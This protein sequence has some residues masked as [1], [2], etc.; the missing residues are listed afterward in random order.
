[1]F[2]KCLCPCFF[3]FVNSGKI[4]YF[5]KWRYLWLHYRMLLY[6]LIYISVISELILI[7]H[8]QKMTGFLASFQKK[9]CSGSWRRHIGFKM[10]N[11]HN[12]SVFLSFWTIHTPKL[13]SWKKLSEKS[14]QNLRH[15][16]ATTLHDVIISNVSDLHI[17]VEWLRGLMTSQN[18]KKGNTYFSKL[19]SG[20]QLSFPSRVFK[21]CNDDVIYNTR[22]YH[23]CV[24]LNRLFQN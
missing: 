21:I 16:L 9:M 20:P 11:H 19:S 8:I 5:V 23:F 17:L 4:N 22:G 24:F 1:M 7:I 2:C 15:H 3:L 6:I 14:K 10:S 18:P 12:L 13:L